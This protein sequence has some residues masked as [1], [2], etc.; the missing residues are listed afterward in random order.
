M[1]KKKN[2][3]CSIACPLAC[4]CACVY[5][6]R[7]EEDLS[8]MVWYWWRCMTFV[9]AEIEKRIVCSRFVQNAKVLKKAIQIFIGKNGRSEFRFVDSTL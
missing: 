9:E 7:A 1:H 4:V 6:K 2:C 3:N 8:K 5:V